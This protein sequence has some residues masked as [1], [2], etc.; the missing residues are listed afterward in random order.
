M[1]DLTSATDIESGD[2]SIDSPNNGGH[3]ALFPSTGKSL[4][5]TTFH[6]PNVQ[7][8]DFSDHGYYSII[9]LPVGVPILGYYTPT[10]YGSGRFKL[11]NIFTLMHPSKD[12]MALLTPRVLYGKNHVNAEYFPKNWILQ[13]MV[14]IRMDTQR[15]WHRDI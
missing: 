8:E 10:K 15:G 9:S 5:K 3:W 13:V 4:G 11:Q 14:L 12:Q 2:P 6:V 1:D 7:A